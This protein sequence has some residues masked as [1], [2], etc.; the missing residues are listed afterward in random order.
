MHTHGLGGDS[1]VRHDPRAAGAVLIVGPRRVV[2]LSVLAVTH[3]DLVHG[4]LDR[5]LTNTLP[6]DLDGVIA[7]PARTTTRYQLSASE[8]AMLDT[9]GEGV[10]ASEVAGSA[11]AGQVLARLVQH[12]FVRLA[13]FTPTDASHVLGRQHTH[14]RAAAL[15]AATLFARARDRRGKP[16]APDA[17]TI[18]RRTIEVL[19]RRSAEAVLAAAFLTDGRPA[20]TATSALVADVLDRRLS[21]VQLSLGLAAPLVGLGASAPAYY[22]QVAELLGA[23]CITPEH[24]GVA[25]AVG[26]VVGRVRI[27]R[28]ATITSP[29]RGLFLVHLPE[30]PG[31][32]TTRE[33]AIEAA[34]QVTLVALRADMVAAGAASFEV[35]ESWTERRA[36]VEGVDMFVEGTLTLTGSGRPGLE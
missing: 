8:A 36:E 18:A 7:M 21:M 9:I 24:A 31:G 35:E 11:V 30:A 22:P 10:A 2:P 19:V 26:A 25:N 13:A 27:S 20:A 14:D 3:P 5:Q 34:R 32:L 17:E 33:A 4:C 23:R 15:K 12:G 28:T 1:Q 6:G 29:T 16:I